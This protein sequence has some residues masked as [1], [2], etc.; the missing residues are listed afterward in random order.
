V[1]RGRL[2]IG[3]PLDFKRNGK[4]QDHASIGLI[5]ANGRGSSETLQTI[6]RSF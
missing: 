3:P 6:D 2:Y 4:G 1:E 5:R